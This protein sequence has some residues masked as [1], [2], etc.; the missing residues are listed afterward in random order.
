MKN[1]PFI[2]TVLFLLFIMKNGFAQKEISI[3]KGSGVFTISGGSGHESDSVDVYYYLPGKFQKHSKILIVVPG[4]G[5]NGDSYRDSWVE[6]SE[7]YNVLILSPSYDESKYPYGDYHLGGTVKDLNIADCVTFDN[8]SNNVFLD[9]E[10]LAF[11]I[12][13]N[14][15]TWIYNDFDRL[16]EMAVEAT[17]SSQKS[18]DMFGHSAG[19]QILHRFVL[20]SPAS[21]AN[22]ILASNAGSYTL[23]DLELTIPFGLKNSGF[24]KKDLKH[25]F[26]KNLVLF[27]GELDNE[28]EKGG[29]LL[30]S[31]TTDKYGIHRLA[32]AQSFYHASNAIAKK[33]NAKVN[34]KLQLVPKVGHNQRKMAVSAAEYLYG[35]HMRG[36]ASGLETP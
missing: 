25:S 14:K 17:G 19:G 33:I 5:R 4:S 24:T 20:F 7:K 18:Y 10:K 31:A 29:L 1:P 27:I 3:E 16:F 12:N 13:L 6:A 23:P 32:R 26:K 2:V 11:T 36:E 22:T 34:W 35:K 30:R 15:K 8:T 28:N 21:K 9:E